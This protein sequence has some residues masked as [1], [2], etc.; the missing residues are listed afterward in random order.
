M[1]KISKTGLTLYGVAPIIADTA[2]R[3]KKI[4]TLYKRGVSV[5]AIANRFNL[6]INHIYLIYKNAR[7]GNQRDT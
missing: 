4:A 6:S 7:A 2:T 5:A 3:N 1:P